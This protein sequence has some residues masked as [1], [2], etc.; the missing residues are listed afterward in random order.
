MVKFKDFGCF[1]STL[2]RILFSRAFQDSP[3]D[4]PVNA[5]SLQACANPVE[6]A[7]DI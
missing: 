3:Q 6:A 1:S 5:S 2:G 7:K 4:S